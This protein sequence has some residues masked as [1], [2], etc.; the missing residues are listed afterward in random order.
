[1][2]RKVI[3]HHIE[4][5]RLFIIFMA[6]KHLQEIGFLKTLKYHLNILQIKIMKT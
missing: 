3:K 6:K 4:L 5:E 2:K 1:M